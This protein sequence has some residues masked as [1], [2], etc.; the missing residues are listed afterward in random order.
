M[1]VF[2]FLLKVW[3]LLRPIGQYKSGKQY[4]RIS[5]RLDPPTIHGESISVAIQTQDIWLQS[6]FKPDIRPLKSGLCIILSLFRFHQRG[7]RVSLFWRDPSNYL[8]ISSRPSDS[9][10][11]Y[12]ALHFPC[13]LVTFLVAMTK[14]LTGA[15][16]RRDGLFWLRVWGCH[17]SPQGRHRWRH[18]RQ[19]VTWHP[20]LRSRDGWMLCLAPPAQGMVPPTC[21]VNLPTST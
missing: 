11:L 4:S 14:Y 7:P 13:I 20:Q 12:P 10:S 2:L 1:S 3:G 9:L 21:R 18:R 5:G 6:D 17:L 19:L 8:T 16:E 15:T